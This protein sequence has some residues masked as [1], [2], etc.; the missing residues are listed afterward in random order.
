VVPADHD[1]RDHLARPNELV[2]RQP[3]FRAVTQAEPAD[4]C[5]K[6]LERDPLGSQLEPSLEE[7]VVGEELTE[8]RIDPRD[9]ARLS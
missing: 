3:R 8:P 9:V 5:G 7:G 2:D 4:P 6:P 1:R